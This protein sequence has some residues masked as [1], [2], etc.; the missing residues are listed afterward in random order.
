[1]EGG[2]P[3]SAEERAVALRTTVEH[4][5]GRQAYRRGDSEVDCPYPMAAGESQKR[6]D[7]F[8][9]YFEAQIGQRLAGVFQ[10]TGIRWP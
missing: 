9:G 5:E 10:R 8:N 2:D 7:W 3:V 4:R 1:M 6:T